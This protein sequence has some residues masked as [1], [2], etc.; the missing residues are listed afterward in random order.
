MNKEKHDRQRGKYIPW[1]EEWNAIVCSRTYEHLA[2]QDCDTQEGIG[3]M[4]EGG[5]VARRGVS[6]LT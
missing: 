1:H 5:A 4:S 3:V 2:C 6:V